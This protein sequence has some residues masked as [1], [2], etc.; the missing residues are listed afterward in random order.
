MTL[1]AQL[2]LRAFL[3]LQ[4][5]HHLVGFHSYQRRLVGCYD[6]VSCQHA[7]FLGRTA[8]N[9]RHHI[10]GVLLHGKLNANTAEAAFQLLCSLLSIV[11]ADISAMGVKLQENLWDGV[12]DK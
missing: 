6:A 5:L 8:M 3:A 1:D 2:H 12:L 7:H 9:H 10:H 4:V 11:G